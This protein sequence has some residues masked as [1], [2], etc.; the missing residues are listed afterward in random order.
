MPVNAC[1]GLCALFGLFNGHAH[2]GE[3]GSAGATAFGI[4]F[5]LSTGLLHAVGV[6]I[7]ATLSRHLKSARGTQVLGA[8]TAM[9]GAWLAVAG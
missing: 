5:A 1:I 2:G 7:A 4:G 9:A 8:L 6:G 3:L